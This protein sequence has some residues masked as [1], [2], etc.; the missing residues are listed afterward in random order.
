MQF[1]V[2]DPPLCLVESAGIHKNII[3]KGPGL[4]SCGSIPISCLLKRR[5]Q[6]SVTIPFFLTIP[7]ISYLLQNKLPIIWPAG[8]H[9]RFQRIPGNKWIWELDIRRLYNSTL[10]VQTNKRIDTQWMLLKTCCSTKC[11]ME[12][13][14]EGPFHLNRVSRAFCECIRHRLV[15]R[16]EIDAWNL[17][18]KW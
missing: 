3:N 8:K 18:E 1:F 5:P 10:E 9:S 2:L 14:G 7:D 11:L 17:V 15:N 13:T 4:R 6:A 16:L 12:P